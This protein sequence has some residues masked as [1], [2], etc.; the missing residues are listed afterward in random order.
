MNK[1]Q[2]AV[3]GKAVDKI[4]VADSGEADETDRTMTPATRL[5]TDLRTVF[6]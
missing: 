2:T 3:T 6:A 4:I 1:D 5:R